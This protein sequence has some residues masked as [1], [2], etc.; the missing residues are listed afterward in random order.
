MSTFFLQDWLPLVRL[1]A[2]SAVAAPLA[3]V[4]VRSG[5]S[6]WKTVFYLFVGVIVLGE[7]VHRGVAFLNAKA[8]DVLTLT[9]KYAGS[10][11]TVPTLE[12]PLVLG[13][14]LILG[15]VLAFPFQRGGS[16][17]DFKEDLHKT[18]TS[19]Q[20][21]HSLLRRIVFVVALMLLFVVVVYLP[22]RLSHR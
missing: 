3:R 14:G 17:Q 4:L 10:A 5:A 2:I 18:L 16:V 22:Y 8:S 1:V 9:V 21:R 19:S 12:V 20:A 7:A 11:Y 6:R 15:G 13:Y